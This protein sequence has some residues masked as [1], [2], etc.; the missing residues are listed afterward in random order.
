MKEIVKKLTDHD[1]NFDTTIRYYYII[2]HPTGTVLLIQ[3]LEVSH[4]T[5]CSYTA[6]YDDLDV[7]NLLMFGL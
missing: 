2:V 1:W 5:V 3:L 7:I 6:V 4:T